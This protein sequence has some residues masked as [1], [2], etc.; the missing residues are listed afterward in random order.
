M[1]SGKRGDRGLFRVRNGE[2][3]ITSA[4]D[5]AEIATIVN[6]CKTVHFRSDAP[7]KAGW[8]YAYL[9]NILALRRVLGAGYIA[10]VQGFQTLYLRM[11]SI[12]LLIPLSL[13]TVTLLVLACLLS[14]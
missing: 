2:I 8:K 13:L 10:S 4:T 14:F 1:G 3:M 6:F 9:G 7:R 5:L 11:R 12:A